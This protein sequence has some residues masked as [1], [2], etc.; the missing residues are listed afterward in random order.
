M[1]THIPHLVELM[2]ADRSFNVL[3]IYDFLQV[4]I[5]DI[6]KFVKNLIYN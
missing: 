4:L 5:N 1:K 6:N 2:S 3:F